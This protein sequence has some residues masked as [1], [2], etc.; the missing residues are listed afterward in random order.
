MTRAKNKTGERFGRWLVLSRAGSNPRGKSAWLCRCDC[1]TERIVSLPSLRSGDSRSCGC[2]NRE[3][4]STHKATGTP[5]YKVWIQMVRRCHGLNAPAIYQ[6][7]G[8]TV[9]DQWRHSFA[10]FLTDMGDRPSLAH[11][12]GRINNEGNYEPTNCRWE[13]PIQQGNNRRNNHLITWNGETNTIAQWERRLG[14]SPKFLRERLRH[15]WT[16]E[17]AVSTPRCPQGGKALRQN[18]RP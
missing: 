17:R 13:T 1:G 9:C 2:L 5:T 18:N 3:V 16:F 11:S 7:R 14:F 8:I 12:I 4:S 10:T 6:G 15:G